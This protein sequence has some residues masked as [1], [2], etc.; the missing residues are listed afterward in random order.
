MKLKTF[1]IFPLA[2]SLF[3]VGCGGG[4][5]TPELSPEQAQENVEADIEPEV[6]PM[7]V[8][9]DLERADG[10]ADAPPPPSGGGAA[11]DPNTANMNPDLGGFDAPDGASD[12]QKTIIQALNLA[13][14]SYDRQRA[15][16]VVEAGQEP[17]PEL[18][19]IEDLVKYRVIRALPPAPAGKKWH[20]NMEKME[21]EL[22]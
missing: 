8:N 13:V 3:S 21:V 5:E 11:P 2:F 15:A 7:V 9:P 18:T 10:G 12:D 19:T 4:D 20:L 14:E 16:S 22:K 17:W 1:V 6:A